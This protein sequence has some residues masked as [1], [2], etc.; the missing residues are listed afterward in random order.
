MLA[1]YSDIPVEPPLA[2][3]KEK[4]DGHVALLLGKA[5]K[6][7]NITAGTSPDGAFLGLAAGADPGV[8]TYAGSDG[9]G[10]IQ[11]SDGAGNTV[12]SAP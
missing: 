10:A 4:P 2:M 9:A 8:F 11:L 5:G 6:H 3:L 1:L 12:W 7:G